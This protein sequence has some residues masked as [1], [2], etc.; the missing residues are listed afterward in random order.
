[1]SEYNAHNPARPVSITLNGGRV[2]E[3]FRSALF[4]AAG[5]QGKSVNEIVLEAAGE[6]LKAAGYH[7]PAVFPGSR[8]NA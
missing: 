2:C 4:E 1:M 5:R 3:G 7:F 6:S 8:M